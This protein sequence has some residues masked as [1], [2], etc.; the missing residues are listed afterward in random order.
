VGYWEGSEEV[1]M[2]ASSVHLAS[3]SLSAFTGGA[4]AI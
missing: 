4:V 2:D 1:V 3:L